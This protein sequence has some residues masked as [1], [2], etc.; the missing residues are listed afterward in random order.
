[1]ENSQTTFPLKAEQRKGTHSMDQYCYQVLYLQTIPVDGQ[2]NAKKVF[3]VFEAV[4]I[5]QKVK[6]QRRYHF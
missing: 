4:Q 3:G 6:N 2:H 1:M 5:S